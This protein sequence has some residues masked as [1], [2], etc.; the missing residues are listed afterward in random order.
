MSFEA[1][2]DPTDRGIETDA[3]RAANAE[4]EARMTDLK[5]QV[6]ESAK[7]LSENQD[8]NGVS[9]AGSSWIN[10]EHD[11]VS[12]ANQFGDHDPVTKLPNGDF[13]IYCRSFG[14]VLVFS[15]MGEGYALQLGRYYNIFPA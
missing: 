11:M 6:E 14:Y 7:Y 12:L 13:A 8:A 3:D 9:V 4:I 10:G 1:P 5:A 15:P 2:I